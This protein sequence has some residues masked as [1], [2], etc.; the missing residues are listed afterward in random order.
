M[1]VGP[2]PMENTLSQP[3]LA[4]RLTIYGLRPMGNTLEK[5][6]WGEDCLGRSLTGVKK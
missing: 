2:R 4:G 6:A 5:I 1:H 3:S